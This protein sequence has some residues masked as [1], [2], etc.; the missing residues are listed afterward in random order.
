M[1]KGYLDSSDTSITTV[2]VANLPASITSVPYSV[3]LYYDGDNGGNNRVGRY[4][5]SGT[6]TGNAVYSVR[7]AAN[8]NYSGFFMPAHQPSTRSR[9]A[10]HPQ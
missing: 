8:T 10:H 3:I 7:D 6:T 1:M 9:A 5:I 4:S 2:N